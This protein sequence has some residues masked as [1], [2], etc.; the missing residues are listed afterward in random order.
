MNDTEENRN[1]VYK[2]IVED[3]GISALEVFENC[4]P[5]V[6]EVKFEDTWAVTQA[7]DVVHVLEKVE[8]QDP[9]LEQVIIKN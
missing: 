2:N 1:K 5:V 6:T 7:F 3:A 8:K 9:E 4:A